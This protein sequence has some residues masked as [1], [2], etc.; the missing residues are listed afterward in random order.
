[1]VIDVDQQN[2]VPTHVQ[3]IIRRSK[4]RLMTRLFETSQLTSPNHVK[5]SN[6]AT[7]PVRREPESIALPLKR[8]QFCRAG[9][10]NASRILK[11]SCQLQ[12]GF[13]FLS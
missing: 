7:L 12:D 11:F 5:A 4:G 1:V 9:D 2:T 10:S 6:A 3:A 8:G 13:A